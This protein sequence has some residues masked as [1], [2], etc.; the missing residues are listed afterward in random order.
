MTPSPAL[1]IAAPM[2]C[3]AFL[4]AFR[5]WLPRLVIDAVA[6]LAALFNLVWALWLLH[7]LVNKH[8]VLVRQLVPAR[9]HG[10]RRWLPG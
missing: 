2:L 10:H 4:A 5:K 7:L 9:P 3:A 1:P 6:I 8:R